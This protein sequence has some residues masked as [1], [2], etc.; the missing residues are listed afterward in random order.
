VSGVVVERGESRGL[1]GLE[2]PTL[3]ETIFVFLK[4]D[5]VLALAPPKLEE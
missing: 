3:Q 5:T 4:L 1:G 2:P